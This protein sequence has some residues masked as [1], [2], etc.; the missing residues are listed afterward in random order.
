MKLLLITLTG[1]TLAGAC[2]SKSQDPATTCAEAA[3]RGVDAMIKQARG[4][5]AGAQLPEDVRVRVQ[6]RQNRLEAAGSKM[7]A[8]FTN[9]CIDDRW[10]PAVLSCYMKVASLEDMRA[11]RKQ[12]TAEQQARLQ[13]DELELLAGN[14]GPQGFDQ[15][16][17][18]GA[19]RVPKDPRIEFVDRAI[20]DARK[21]VAD[22]RTPEDEKA[23]REQLAALEG[24]K[25]QLE[26]QI[27]ST[28][29]P[30]A[31]AALEKEVTEA[32]AKLDA[33]E[34]DRKRSDKDRAEAGASYLRALDE[35]ESAKNRQR[36]ADLSAKLENIDNRVS[37]LAKGVTGA[38]SAAARDAAKAEL[39]ALR[40]EHEK[41]K[42]EFQSLIGVKRP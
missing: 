4:R 32:K 31:I 9:R 1:V 5:L 12:L 37:G 38:D 28:T 25:K 2:G 16:Q 35:L 34:K 23:A 7:R 26:D 13:K 30:E 3:K 8:V 18:G 10:A 15:S 22:A 24:E 21:L 27:A 29:T 33:M 39:E 42:L 19:F 20:N 6:E 36:L 41:L 11:C 14:T 17:P 40:A